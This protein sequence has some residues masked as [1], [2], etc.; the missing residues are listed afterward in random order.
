VFITWSGERAK[1]IAEAL[2]EWLPNVI[3]SVEP[4]MSKKDI[5]PGASWQAELNKELDQTDF[6]IV[7]LTPE[8]LDAPWVYYEAGALAKKVGENRR[9]VCPYLVDISENTE[10]TGPLAQFQS[11][12]ANQTETLELLKAINRATERKLEDTRLEDAF[13]LYW[14]RLEKVISGLS[15]PSTK[16]GE[17]SE[18]DLLK[19]ILETV[20][21]MERQLVEGRGSHEDLTPEARRVFG[22]PRGSLRVETEEALRV[23]QEAAQRFRGPFG[24]K[25]AEKILA[26]EALRAL[27]ETGQGKPQDAD[28]KVDPKPKS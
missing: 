11:T 17:R 24:A 10:V 14:P 8:N 25:E 3:Q 28:E 4:W 15:V 16:P 26:K 12:L 21:S 19:E 1:N 9:K 7:V 20:R 23:I 18:L 6:G 22:I 2:H 13:K 27:Q 5:M